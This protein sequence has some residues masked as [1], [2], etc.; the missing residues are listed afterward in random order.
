MKNTLAYY[1]P[2][3]D[4]EWKK[5]YKIEKLFFLFRA[6]AKVKSWAREPLP[7]GKAQ[8]SWPLY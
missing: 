7:K 8:Y 1:F 6:E 2:T 3:V 5:F 4:D